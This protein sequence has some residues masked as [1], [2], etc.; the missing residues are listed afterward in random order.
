[1]P[2]SLR[3]ALTWVEA[4]LGL[5]LE[6]RGDAFLTVAAPPSVAPRPALAATVAFVY[7]FRALLDHTSCVVQ[8]FAS[9]FMLCLIA[10]LRVRDAQRAT[11]T[12]SE[13]RLDGLCYMATR[14]WD[15]A[16]GAP[17]RNLSERQVAPH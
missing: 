17:L 7:H 1:M 16:R 10:C 4:H 8:Y 3:S 15:V 2:S 14:C 11:V 12:V 6:V 13:E 5:P 9:G